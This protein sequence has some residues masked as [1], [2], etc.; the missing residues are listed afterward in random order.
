MQLSLDCQEDRLVGRLH[1]TDGASGKRRGFEDIAEGE[2]ILSA[3]IPVTV[4]VKDIFREGVIEGA[5]G[6][7][8]R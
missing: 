7:A 8:A 2:V 1:F 4:L 5:E 6:I 3:E